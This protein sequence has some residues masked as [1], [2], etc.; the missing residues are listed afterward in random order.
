[1]KKYSV[2]LRDQPQLSVKT[3]AFWIEYIICHDGAGHLRSPGE[4]LNF[5]QYY[6]LDVAT[7]FSIIGVF[8]LLVT[9][10]TMKYICNKFCSSRKYKSK[11]DKSKKVN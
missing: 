8:C 11:Q 7:L 4:N 10:T 1:M 5:I 2:I 9:A 6:L 3:A